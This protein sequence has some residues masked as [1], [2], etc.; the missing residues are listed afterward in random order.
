MAK[1]SQ[2]ARF[3]GMLA[4]MVDEDLRRLFEPALLGQPGRAA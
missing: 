1:L 4:Q 3:L 2:S